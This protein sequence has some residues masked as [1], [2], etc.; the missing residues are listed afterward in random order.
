VNIA[1]TCPTSAAGSETPTGV[2]EA[3]GPKGSDTDT[4][5]KDGDE[6]ECPVTMQKAGKWEPKVQFSITSL[7]LSE[8]EPCQEL[9]PLGSDF[10]RGVYH[11]CKQH[12]CT[13]KEIL[14]YTPPPGGGRME[15]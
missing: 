1:V 7:P 2:P 10:W 15:E 6:P 8:D 13:L 5:K 12:D 11:F 4:K 3:E 14:D 9:F